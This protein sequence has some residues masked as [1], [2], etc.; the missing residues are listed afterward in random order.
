MTSTQFDLIHW[1]KQTTKGE[2]NQKFRKQHMMMVCINNSYASDLPFYLSL[3][4]KIKFRLS[5]CVIFLI[6]LF[7]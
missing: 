1:C 4:G 5:K 3:H 6:N 2:L 7:L